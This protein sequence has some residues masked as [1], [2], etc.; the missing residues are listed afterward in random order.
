MD[1]IKV[2]EEDGP[3]AVNIQYDDPVRGQVKLSF[4]T[5]RDDPLR[6]IMLDFCDRMDL[7]YS[8]VTFR[9]DGENIRE[10]QKPVDLGMADDDII[11]AFTH[12]QGGGRAS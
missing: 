11:D 8:S 4:L 7:V 9:L 10:T 12:L 2:K 1:T 6:R 5:H 3:T